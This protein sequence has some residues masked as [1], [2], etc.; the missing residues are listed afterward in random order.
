L[1]SYNRYLS[2][3]G[4]LATVPGEPFRTFP[5]NAAYWRDRKSI[6]GFYG[7]RCRKCGASI[8]PVNRVCH[9]CGTKDEFDF[10]MLADRQAKVFTFSIDKLA[11]RADDP[12]V[13]QT[14]AEDSDGTRYYLTMTDFDEAELEI[15]LDVEFRFRRIYEGGNYINYYWKCSPIRNGGNAQ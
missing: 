7:S 2:F 13:A 10:V 9:V 8:F 15:G 12:V 4:L 14:V 1:Q 11:G 5:S 6:L 3:R